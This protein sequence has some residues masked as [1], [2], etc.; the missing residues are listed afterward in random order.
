MKDIS[1]SKFGDKSFLIKIPHTPTRLKVINQ[2]MWHIE[3]QAMFVATWK[4]GLTPVMPELTEVPVWQEFRDVPLQYFSEE[5]LE[6]I[7]GMLGHPK[8]C[9]PSTINMTNLEVAKVFTIVDPRKNVPEAVNVQFHTG[10]IHRI[11]VSCPWLPP[12]CSHCQE[13]GHSIK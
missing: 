9:H 11:R 12:L 2:G 13:L 5:G 3:D 1:V 10:E 8:L 7:A 4:P 6:H